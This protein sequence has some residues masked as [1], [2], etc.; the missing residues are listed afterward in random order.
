MNPGM[1]LLILRSD[2]FI[3]RR[4]DISHSQE[5]SLRQPGAFL[6]FVRAEYRRAHALRFGCPC[7]RY[8]VLAARNAVRLE[9]RTVHREEL[10]EP[11]GLRHHGRQYLRLR[12]RCFWRASP[13]GRGQLSHAAPACELVRVDRIFFAHKDSSS[14]RVY[15]WSRTYSRRPL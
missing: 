12:N 3:A 5:E 11:R 9:Q 14:S 4:A 7:A 15:H 6:G 13:P 2:L 10:D 8:D 1:S